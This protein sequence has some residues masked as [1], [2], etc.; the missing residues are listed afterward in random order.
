M[1]N[2][3]QCTFTAVIVAA[4]GFFCVK[5]SHRSIPGDLRDA[6]ADNAAF[7]NFNTA[8]S[9]VNK[10]TGNI[11]LP[12]APVANKTGAAACGLIH[13][14]KAH[15]STWYDLSNLKEINTNFANSGCIKIAGLRLWHRASASSMSQAEELAE[16]LD[17]TWVKLSGAKRKTPE[18]R[19]LLAKALIYG[20]DNGKDIR[21]LADRVHELYTFYKE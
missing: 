1:N 19:E 12:K 6:P 5:G 2:W 7:Q 18:S 10:D 20:L 17:S 4:V 14:D 11:P 21:W 13:G 9:G 15:I 16:K 8:I 3:K